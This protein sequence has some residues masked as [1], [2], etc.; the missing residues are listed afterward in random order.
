MIQFRARIWKRVHNDPEYRSWM[1]FNT[2]DNPV[3][4]QLDESKAK[5]EPPQAL[6]D[7]QFCDR[8]THLPGEVRNQIYDELLK[9][10]SMGPEPT[11]LFRSIYV[12]KRSHAAASFTGPTSLPVNRFTPLRYIGRH[13]QIWDEVSSRWTRSA[14]FRIIEAFELHVKPPSLKD[15]LLFRHHAPQD[16]PFKRYE[17]DDSSLVFEHSRPWFSLMQSCLVVIHI[18]NICATGFTDDRLLLARLHQC[19]KQIASV[20]QRAANMD[21]LNMEL[22]LWPESYQ[23]SSSMVT[24]RGQKVVLNR[25]LLWAGLEPLKQVQ[26]IRTIALHTGPAIQETWSAETDA[27]VVCA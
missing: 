2:T 25:D 20:L 23:K 27:T 19:M 8:F 22:Y 5:S 1:L 15:K 11:P 12:T 13:R 4:K 14:K 18:F 24:W 7:Q 17:K 6:H 3:N 26:G 16:L 9:H 10:E 21:D